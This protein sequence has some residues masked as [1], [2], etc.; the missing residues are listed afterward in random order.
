MLNNLSQFPRGVSQLTEEAVCEKVL[1]K[2]KGLGNGVQH[3][4]SSKS[5][6]FSRAEVE[7]ANHRAEESERRAKVFRQD[8]Q[9]QRDQMQEMDLRQKQ[10]DVQIQALLAS[11]AVHIPASR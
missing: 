5:S 9:I 11:Q 1:G 8:L 7:R 3:Q 10:M 6:Q 2:R 4:P